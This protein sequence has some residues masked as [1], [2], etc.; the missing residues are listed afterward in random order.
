MSALF[1][2]AFPAAIDLGSLYGLALRYA[3]LTQNQGKLSS[4]PNAVANY[5]LRVAGGSTKP[6]DFVFLCRGNWT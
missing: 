4:S 6:L 5:A 1:G 2:E 3:D